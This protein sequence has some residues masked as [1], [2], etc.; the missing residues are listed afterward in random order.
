[1]NSSMQMRLVR[2]QDIRY[3][4][5]IIK[6]YYSM[7]C[8]DKNKPNTIDTLKRT[9]LSFY[10]RLLCALSV[11]YNFITLCICPFSEI[12]HEPEYKEKSHS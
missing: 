6:N 5:D 1:M 3:T 2:L 10:S 11:L 4:S 7:A 12:C 8:E 9:S